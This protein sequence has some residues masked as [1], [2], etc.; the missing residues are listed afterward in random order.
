MYVHAVDIHCSGMKMP[1]SPTKGAAEKEV[2][3][4]SCITS[5]PFHRMQT[6]CRH[7]TVPKP[8]KQHRAD[9]VVYEEVTFVG[10]TAN[11]PATRDSGAYE[12]VEPPPLQSPRGHG[13]HS[14]SSNDE[15]GYFSTTRAAGSNTWVY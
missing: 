11:Q 9:A 14:T 10:S 7:P 3:V 2:C 1:S 6:D 15:G 13:L 12:V 5:P 4:S 8:Y